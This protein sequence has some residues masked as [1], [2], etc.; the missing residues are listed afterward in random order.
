VLAF[1]IFSFFTLAYP[2]DRAARAKSWPE[3][4][5]TITVSE[6][7]RSRESG[8]EQTHPKLRYR[9]EI[10]GMPYDG[11]RVHFGA[12][13]DVG[14]Y[15]GVHTIRPYP[16]GLRTTCRVNPYDPEDS[17]LIPEFRGILM[18]LAGAFCG[19]SFLISLVPFSMVWW[20]FFTRQPLTR[21]PPPDFDA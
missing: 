2:I 9:Y 13:D 1:G 17:V 21:K 3:V 7:E 16:V 4:P 6:I 8:R 5:C 20:R 14:E 12:F 11:D 15:D 10:N 18:P 19:I